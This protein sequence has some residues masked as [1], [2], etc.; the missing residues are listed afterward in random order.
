MK[1]KYRAYGKVIPKTSRILFIYI[2]CN[3][4]VIYNCINFPI[5]QS[6]QIV[7]NERICKSLNM[8]CHVRRFYML[9]SFLLVIIERNRIFT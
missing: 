5:M 2:L 4:D 7:N 1:R 3:R 8:S 6:Y 9:K